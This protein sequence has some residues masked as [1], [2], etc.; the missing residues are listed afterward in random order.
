MLENK[1][2]SAVGRVNALLTFN[3]EGQEQAIVAPLIARAYDREG[4][5]HVFGGVCRL[6][7]KTQNHLLKI[8][9]PAVELLFS[10]LK[11]SQKK[12][13]LS[14]TNIGGTSL[15]DIGITTSGFSADAAVYIAAVSAGLQIPVDQG[16]AITGHIASC[17]GDI[18]AVKNMPAK[19]KAAINS[20]TIHTM[21][22]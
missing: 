12:Y 14:I 4:E 16:L 8:V 3:A 9:F 17:D 11:L 18:K 1:E 10:E 21:I 7:D 20:Q 5:G 2:N 15:H 22:I 6:S 19:I 13:H